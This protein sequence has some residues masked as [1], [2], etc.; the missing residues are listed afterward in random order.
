MGVNLLWVHIGK[1]SEMCPNKGKKCLLIKFARSSFPSNVVS[2]ILI[3]DIDFFHG[4]L[5]TI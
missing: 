5:Q 2:N 4:L 3:L 1:V